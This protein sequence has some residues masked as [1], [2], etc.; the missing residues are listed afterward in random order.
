MKQTIIKKFSAFF[1]ENTTLLG[2]AA[3]NEQIGNAEKVLHV[4]MD[5]N[6]KEFILN[7]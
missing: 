3:T 6:Y 4:V 5:N 2:I 1:K 7:F